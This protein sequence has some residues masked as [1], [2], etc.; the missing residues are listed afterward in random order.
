[1]CE[2]VSCFMSTHTAFDAVTIGC[3]NVFVH[4]V[5]VVDHAYEI[6]PICSV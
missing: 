5:F 2:S 1:M 6:Y 3:E 4:L